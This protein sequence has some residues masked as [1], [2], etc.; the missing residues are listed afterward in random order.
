MGTKDNVFVSE[1]ANAT[2]YGKA[3]AVYNGAV[4]YFD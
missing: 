4:K 3:D 1:P 2:M